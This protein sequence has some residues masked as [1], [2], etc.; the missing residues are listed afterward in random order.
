[1]FEAEVLPRLEAFQ[2][3]MVFISAGFDAHRRTTWASSA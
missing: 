3:E 1:V 2:P